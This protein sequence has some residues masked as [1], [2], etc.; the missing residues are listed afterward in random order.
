MSRICVTGV[1][2]QIGSIVAN[3]LADRLP[4]AQLVF[5]SRQPSKL[6]HFA[7]QGIDIRALDYSE[8]QQFEDAFEGCD[9]VLL[10]SGT[11]IGKRIEQHRNAIY[12]AKKAGV[13]HI[14]YTSVSGC[15]PKNPT[16]SSIEHWETEQ[17]L[18]ESGLNFTALRDQM[19]SE[20]I[21][22]LFRSGIATGEFRFPGEGGMMSPVSVF[23]IAATIVE[24]LIKPEEHEKVTYE[25]TGD[26]LLTFEEITTRMS[27]IYGKPIK[28]VSLSNEET[29]QL[30][31]DRGIP[32]K[33]DPSKPLPHRYGAEEL[34]KNYIAW[35]DNFHAIQSASVEKITGNKPRKWDDV[36]IQNKDHWDKVFAQDHKLFTKA[37]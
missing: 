20:L 8:P 5:T 24:I 30:M 3:S 22:G 18:I 10:I 34:S 16:P 32:Y 36:V 19:Y 26:E 35:A 17:M 13:K 2:G 11:E 14:V 27:E 25:V 37:R 21:S 12:G 4:A 7:N 6:E 33:G 28:Y 9:T 15:H 1:T 31:L 29:L 23:D